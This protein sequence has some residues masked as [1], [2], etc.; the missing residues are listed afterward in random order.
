MMKHRK[1]HSGAT[2][3]TSSLSVEDAQRIMDD[4]KNEAKNPWCAHCHCFHVVACPRVRSIEWSKGEVSRVEFW[5][6]WSKKEVWTPLE[7]AD[8]AASDGGK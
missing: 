3:V 1:K 2:P 4:A 8:I 6:T 7:V 5:P